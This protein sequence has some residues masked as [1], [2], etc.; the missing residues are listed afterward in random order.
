MNTKR[1]DFLIS[2]PNHHW[3]MVKPIIRVLK[4]RGEHTLRVISL[5]EFRRM[6]TPRASIAEEGVDLIVLPGFK[7]LG[8][9]T[10]AGKKSL[11]SSTS[12]KRT[13][14]QRMVWYTYV[15]GAWNRAFADGQTQVLMLLNDFAYPNNFITKSLHR[16][17]I[18][19]CLLQEGI[20]FP[21]P[22]EPAEQGKGY[23]SMGSKY[24]FA[25]GAESR[26]YFEKT[27]SG[28]DFKVV[29]TGCPRFDVIR[30]QSFATEIDDLKDKYPQGN[31]T[32]GL[33]SNPIDDQGFCTSEEK[34]DL[35]RRFLTKAVPVVERVNG[36]I[37]IKLHPREDA[38]SVQ[39][40]INNGNWQQTV[41]LVQGN[42]FAVLKVVDVS[43]VLAS[44]VGLESLLMGKPLG[45][46]SLP[47]YG[48]VFNYV[49]SGG[50]TGLVLD[51][52]EFAEKLHQFIRQTAL[53]P[54]A[55][56]YLKNSIGNIGT[57]AEHIADQLA[58]CK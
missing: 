11:G 15:R 44:T 39:Q 51:D 2:N 43:I 22:N 13:A 36:R 55:H 24:L 1:I 21:L 38:A 54:D 33:F 31:I 34:E 30:G 17:N 52:D 7:R 27:L 19:F 45:V 40:I 6:E 12:F 48:F 47:N 35:L 5:C 25:W 26:T 56:A 3:Q 42:I 29:V 57:S 32:L 50:A 8:L 14:V 23:G 20:R 46:L 28:K 10:S 18:P 9:E 58:K 37:W 16:K 4:Q 49:Q 53:S 41:S